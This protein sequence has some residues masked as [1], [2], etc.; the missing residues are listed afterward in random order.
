[1]GSMARGSSNRPIRRRTGSD[2][3][4]ER[5]ARGF[6]ILEVMFAIAVLGIMFLAISH[7]LV[8][9]M[10]LNEVNRETSLAQ[11]AMDAQLENLGG[12]DFATVFRRY[13]S[14]PGD[15]PAL[16]PSPGPNFA[17]PGLDPLP[18][19]PDGFVGKIVLPEFDAGASVELH[20]DLD[21]PELG[22]PRDL[23]GDGFIDN[24]NHSGDYRQLPVLLQLDWKGQSGRRHSVARTV[25]AHR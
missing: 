6:T 24:A 16:G 7:S 19:D 2:A 3:Q 5:R 8:G 23:N 25:L 18:D 12:A 20:E 17:V 9:S 14:I 4:R 21:M 13:D 1:M 10:K 22:M 15:D 11:Q